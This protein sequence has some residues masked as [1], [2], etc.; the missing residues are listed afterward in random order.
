MDIQTLIVS[1]LNYAHSFPTSFPF[2]SSMT[3]A[4]LPRDRSEKETH[5]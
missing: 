5:V 1:Y 4:G 2:L 3:A